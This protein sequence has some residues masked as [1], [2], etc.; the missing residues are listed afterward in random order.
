MAFEAGGRQ[1][2]AKSANVVDEEK[3]AFEQHGNAVVRFQIM[4]IRVSK[5][6]L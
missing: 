2:V 4:T 6:H 3:Q 5:T 1:A